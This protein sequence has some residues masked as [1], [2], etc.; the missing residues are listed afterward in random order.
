M[1]GVIG[2]VHK[3]KMVKKS[4][5]E[6]MARCLLHRGPDDEGYFLHHFQDYQIGLAHRRLSILDLSSLGHQPMEFE[7]LVITYNGEIYNF[8]EIRR[9]LTEYGYAFKS[10]SDT[11]VILKAF[12]HWGA[13]AVNRFTGMFA[14]GIYDKRS[15]ELHLFRDRMGLKPLYYYLNDADIFFSSE[16]KPLL[17]YPYF[18]K[19]LN[20][21]ALYMYLYH[22]Y[23]VSPHSVYSQVFKLEP[24][25]HLHFKNGRVQIDRYWNLREK[26]G[27]LTERLKDESGVIA[28]LDEILT[29]AVKYRMISD[30]P[31]GALLSGGYDSSLITAV[32]QKLSPQ[33]INTFTVG[34][35][36]AKYNEADYAKKVARHLGTNH[37]EVY[38]SMHETKALIPQ[39]SL[40]FDEPFGDSSV[41]P[42]ILINKF[43]KS[44][45]TV[46]LTGDGGDE[47]FCGYNSYDAV[48]RLKKFIPVGKIVSA[49]GNYLSLNALLKHFGVRYLKYLYLNSNP[50]LINYGYLLS[51]SYL[52]GIIP[53]QPLKME[54]KYLKIPEVSGNI[55][56]ANMFLD[57]LTYLP[58]D[59]L[60][61]MDGAS[62]SVSLEARVPLL[63]HH[64][65]QYALQIDHGLKYNQGTK[66]VLKELAHKYI[67]AN[68]LQ[69]PKQ[70][71]AIP[72]NLWLKNE[73]NYLLQH[74][75]E[76]EYV[77][78]Q[79]IFN[80][81]HI[82]VLKHGFYKENKN[83][84]FTKLV[85]NLV[86]FQLWSERYL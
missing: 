79:G 77:R 47:L 41:L 82:N 65:V 35:V 48:L 51:K 80:Y 29:R 9:E 17:K 64:V 56:E 45:V 20:F 28:G 66:Y 57:M 26:Y 71:F 21:H 14:L 43:A 68:L 15:N 24:G 31:I 59:I 6:E 49:A 67:P 74:Y 2:F 13:P 38:L 23:I 75:L 62:M 32:M 81:D 11:E 84:F 63:D 33:P 30:V 53:D 37:H 10:E 60:K 7:N 46:V 8:K 16:L 36:E 1:C 76:K 12:H 61:K 19:E 4:L 83:G 86:I 39:I 3:N 44:V 34:F 58:D 50:S 72:V 54:S 70:G 40:Y 85:W 5:L 55:Q 78:N 42:T 73:L 69:R 27:Q 52:T 22:G 18:K 25:C